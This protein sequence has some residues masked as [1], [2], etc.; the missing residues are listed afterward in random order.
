M[1][2]ETFT[3]YF[4]GDASGSMFHGKFIVSFLAWLLSLPNVHLFIIS[5]KAFILL[6][7]WKFYVLW[8]I[9]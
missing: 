8:W 1:I 3:G 6:C 7:V 9:I 5:F 2:L 4:L